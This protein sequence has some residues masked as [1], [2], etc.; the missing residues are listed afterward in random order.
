M[1]TWRD[2]AWR[3]IL[4]VDAGLPA[5]ISFAGRKRAIQDAYPYGA[6]KGWPYKAWLQAQREYLSRFNPKRVEGTPGTIFAEIQIAAD[7][8][9]SRIRR[10]R[11]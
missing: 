11:S 6:R 3:V 7:G 5:D 2:N 1:T 8:P 10:E 9:H 4:K